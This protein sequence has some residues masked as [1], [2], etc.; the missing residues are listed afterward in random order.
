MVNGLKSLKRKEISK[1]AD[2]V[3]GPRSMVHEKKKR[4]FKSCG[5]WTVDCR[6]KGFTLVEVCV[7]TAILA[8]GVVF[9]FESFFIVLDLYQTHRDMMLLQPVIHERLWDVQNSLTRF[10]YITENV[11]TQGIIDIDTH[12]Y[13]WSA[14]YRMIGGNQPLYAIRI[15][16]SGQRGRRP[17]SMARTSYALYT[18]PD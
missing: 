12:P 8:I 2:R 16:V 15:D 5:L 6:Q 3:H 4:L 7:A 18:D 14:S 1:I 9:I 10:G 13:H 17:V 11:R